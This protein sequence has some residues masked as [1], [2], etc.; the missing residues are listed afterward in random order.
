MWGI[1]S[2]GVAD[3]FL[4]AIIDCESGEWRDGGTMKPTHFL[5]V[6]A[7]LLPGWLVA[8]G[9]PPVGEKLVY[10]TAPDR[11]ELVLYVTKPDDWKASD[12]RPAILFFHG[13]GWTGGAPGQFTAHAEHLAEKGMVVFQVQYRLLDKKSKDAPETCVEDAR[14]AM[15]WVRERAGEFGIDPERIGSGGGSAGGH[16]AAYLGMVLPEGDA[17]K[18]NAMV[19]F[20]PVLD[21]GPGGW[22]HGRVGERYQEFSP[23]HNVSPDDPPMLVMSG[24]KDALISPET[25]AKLKAASTAA[26]VSCE[27][28]I[29]P[30]AGHGYFNKS[31]YYEE[32]VAQMDAFLADLGWIDRRGE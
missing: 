12:S 22:G 31:P 10:K 32:T 30:D 24:E 13:G 21:N 15:R 4:G 2:A 29:T 26:G 17:G 28:R 18:A 1:D 8:V 6:L 5:V 3:F 19:L 25:F 11:G 20:N 7:V 9:A 27:V 14:D 23:F 16:L